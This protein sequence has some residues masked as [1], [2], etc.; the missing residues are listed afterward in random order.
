MS[1]VDAGR[2]ADYQKLNL[3]K[4]NLSHARFT[5]QTQGTAIERLA[6]L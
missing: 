3:E 1:W 2:K 6:R 4:L 5:A